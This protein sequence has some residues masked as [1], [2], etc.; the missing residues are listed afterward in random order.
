MKTQN[1]PKGAMKVLL[2]DD[3]DDFL[4]VMEELIKGQGHTLLIARD[5]KQAREFLE[6]ESVDVIISDIFM[7]TL[8]GIR[9]HSYVRELMGDRK[10]P[11]IFMSGYD[12][13]YTQEAIEDSSI[14][15]FISKLTPISKVIE[16][17][18]QIQ[19]SITN[20]EN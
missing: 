2:A 14:D 10:V 12:D 7:P 17:L 4:L 19:S 6:E 20:V 3:N 13:P 9:F 16:V 1:E 18:D 11:F 8:D 5:G 15:L